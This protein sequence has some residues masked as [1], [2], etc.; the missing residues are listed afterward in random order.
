MRNVVWGCVGAGH[1]RNCLFVRGHGPLLQKQSN[2]LEVI[3][4]V[5]RSYKKRHSDLSTTFTFAVHYISY[6]PAGC[7]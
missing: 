7:L 4:G 6:F 5:T 3:A 1:A 2:A